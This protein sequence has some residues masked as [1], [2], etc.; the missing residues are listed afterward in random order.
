MTPRRIG[1]LSEGTKLQSL[2]TMPFLKTT[3]IPQRNKQCLP[4]CAK[5]KREGKEGQHKKNII[6]S[7]KKE[8]KLTAA[9]KT[10]IMQLTMQF[11]RRSGAPSLQTHAFKLAAIR[12]WAFFKPTL[13][14]ACSN[15]NFSQPSLT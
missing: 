12:L 5:K 14:K 6:L 11:L 10:T 9:S 1:I 4:P 8:K 15:L 3:P 2:V 7:L 13:H